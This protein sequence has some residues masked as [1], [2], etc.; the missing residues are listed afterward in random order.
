MLGGSGEA[1]GSGGSGAP[2]A[3]DPGLHGPLDGLQHGCGD[4]AQVMFQTCRGPWPISRHMVRTLKRLKCVKGKVQRIIV[5]DLD[6]SRTCTCK[7]TVAELSH[8]F[9]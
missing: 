2:W 5:D 3:I 8:K 6:N 4:L 9:D 1:G 7:Q